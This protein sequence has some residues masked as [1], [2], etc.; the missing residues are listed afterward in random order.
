MLSLRRLLRGL[1]SYH[2]KM[3]CTRADTAVGFAKPLGG[4]PGRCTLPRE[5]QVA[6]HPLDDPWVFCPVSQWHTGNIGH[7]TPSP[8]GAA[9]GVPAGLQRA[10]LS[11]PSA[12]KAHRDQHVVSSRRRTHQ[13]WAPD[14]RCV[15]MCGCVY[16]WVCVYVCGH[17][18]GAWALGP[19]ALSAERGH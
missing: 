12:P 11:V 5:E 1:C 6:T 8:C 19:Q 14:V 9:A 18:P 17:G 16:V 10:V 13:R 4:C 2:N 3:K 7:Q 15:C